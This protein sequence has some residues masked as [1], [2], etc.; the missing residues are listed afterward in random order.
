MQQLGVSLPG[1]VKV[2]VHTKTTV[3]NLAA[4]GFLGLIA[5]LSINFVN[6]FCCFS[7]NVIL[8][9]L[10]KGPWLHDIAC[11]EAWC[12]EKPSLNFPSFLPQEVVL[13]CSQVHPTSAGTRQEDPLGPFNCAL[14][15]SYLLWEMALA[16]TPGSA[17]QPF[18]HATI[19][20]DIQV[21]CPPALINPFL[22]AFDWVATSIGA[23][24]ILP[25]GDHVKSITCLL[26]D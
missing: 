1:D 4:G 13:P 5:I 10:C 9:F 2:L 21:F 22:Q 3:E 11:W 25:Q 18:I 19:I 12:Q 8:C 24:H 20:D 16:L 6:A 15:V 17:H 7:W 14:C 26:G 23:T